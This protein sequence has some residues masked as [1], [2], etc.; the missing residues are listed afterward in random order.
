MAAEK[1]DAHMLSREQLYELVWNTPTSRLKRNFGMSDVAIAKVCKRM[2]VPKPPRGYWAKLGHGKSAARTPLEPLPMGHPLSEDE[3]RRRPRSGTVAQLRIPKQA[4]TTAVSPAAFV[5]PADFRASHPLIRTTRAAL[6]SAVKAQSQNEMYPRVHAVGVGVLDVSVGVNSIDAALRILHALIGGLAKIGGEVRVVEEE[7]R[8]RNG[9]WSMK[10][11][12]LAA[13][14]QFHIEESTTR[15]R[16]V[17]TPEERRNPWSPRQWDY[18]PTGILRLHLDEYAEDGLRKQ[19]TIRDDES[20]GETLASFVDGVVVMAQAVQM[21][22][23]ANERRRLEWERAERVKRDEESRIRRLN[24]V[25][26]AWERT[27]G[28]RGFLNALQDAVHRRTGSSKPHGPTVAW[29]E[30]AK[31]HVA[32]S[33]PIE[34]LLQDL[35]SEKVS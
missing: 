21:R 7:S 10:I 9:R 3:R 22:D 28:L 20:V 13:P 27:N 31:R 2:K 29:L 19:W 33:D 24:D 14:V 18:T 12:G 4:G 6:Q 30:W 25:F 11:I 8:L 1:L 15:V 23:E 26:N 34:S 35:E 17:P 32:S 16:H 5:M